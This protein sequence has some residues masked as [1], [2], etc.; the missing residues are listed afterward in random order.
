MNGIDWRP[1]HR[2]VTATQ[3]LLKM[4]KCTLE[5]TEFLESMILEKTVF[6]YVEQS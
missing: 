3:L 4:P 2:P 5:K 1:R 6:A